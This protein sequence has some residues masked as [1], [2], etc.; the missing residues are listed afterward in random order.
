MKS[1][2]WIVVAILLL[3]L[4]LIA[5]LSARRLRAPVEY[6][7]GGR[8]A[9]LFQLIMLAFGSGTSADSQG[10]VMSGA[11]RAGLSG[12]W[13]QFL[14]LPITPF[15]WILAPLLR[16]LRAVTTADFFTMRFGRSTS[17][18]YSLYGMIICVVL[19]AGILFASARL[20][21]VL[22]DPFFSNAANKLH[23]QIPSVDLK[24]VFLPPA[25]DRPAILTWRALGGEGLAAASLGLLLAICGVIGGL[26]AAI[27]T[28]VIQGCVRIVLT[29]VLLPLMF[30]R[31]GGFGL[32]HTFE[33]LKPGM[34]DFVVN[35][36][37]R[38]EGQQDPFT[39]FYL[40]M[41]AVAGL[42]GIIA[43]PHI[44]TMCGAGHSELDARIGFTFGN[45]LKR[46]VSVLWAFLGLACVAWYLGPAS[47]LEGPASTPADR[48]L[49]VQL[50]EVADGSVEAK[51]AEEQARARTL[52]TR[53]ADRLFGRMV[54]DLTET[55]PAGLRGLFAAIVIAAAVSHCG[56]QM[57]VASGL[58][59]EHFYKHQIR[60]GMDPHHYLT[61]GRLCG[62]V[63]VL[64]ALVLQM[65]FANISDVMRLVIKTPAVIGISM[66]MGLIWT[67]WNT[68][69]VWVTTIV[70]A[71]MGILCGYF[72]EEVQRTFPGLTHLMFTE[73]PQGLIMMDAWKILLI[74]ASGLSAGIIGTFVTDLMQDS[75]LEYFYRVIR[76]PVSPDEATYGE[77]YQPPDDIELLPC[78]AFWGFQLPGP[79]RG[80]LLGFTVAWLIVGG[81][82]LVT[83]WVSL[84]F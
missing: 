44:M 25:V 63:L 58:F 64:A 47:P 43:Q 41:L 62:P 13:W 24:A 10:S 52:D 5:A 45:L 77:D 55:L 4:P 20:L 28:D 79:T 66:W 75:Q 39:P 11:W 23:F 22:T 18:L 54:R 50:R 12:L 15:Y 57:V 74:L 7:T 83:K 36:E 1:A 40:F 72:P 65:S 35:A 26:N 76:T 3:M 67:R 70:S 78:V 61:V 37:S 16:R 69:S 51:P 33:G 73:T 80:G 82:V 60:P 38:L 48:E 21:N 49:L 42:A 6:Y 56:T 53:F 81:L 14:W 29:I 19:M 59:A 17:L 9:G 34:F 46:C 31:I 2:D 84:V 8:R 27:V 32:L 68:V 30:S 71:G